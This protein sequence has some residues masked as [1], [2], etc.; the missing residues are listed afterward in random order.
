MVKYLF[1][2]FYKVRQRKWL[3]IYLCANSILLPIL[4]KIL[5]NLNF[6]TGQTAEGQYLDH[7]AF[8]IISF[9][10]FYLFLP[11]WILIVSGIEFTNGHY[12]LVIFHKSR[13]FYFCS[14]VVYCLMISV[15]FS[16]LGLIS[17]LLIQKTAPFSITISVQVFIE[18][19]IQSFITFFSLSLFQLSIIFFTRNPITGFIVY[20]FISFGERM[21]YTL[22]MKIYSI[23]L[24]YLPLHLL[25]SFYVRSGEVKSEN[26]YNPFSDFDPRIAL[27]PVLLL[28]TLGLT[29]L[30]LIKKDIKSLSD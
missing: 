1:F 4:T 25:N 28:F 11:V 7:A 9:S 23:D 3:L 13:W 30:W 21:I 8:G 24:F 20:F 29:Y 15:Y 27:L 10:S 6:T 22:L 16:L 5:T 19:F 17:L 14:K 18:F 26:Y 2:E 12:S